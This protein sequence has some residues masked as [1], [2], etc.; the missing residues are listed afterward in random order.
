MKL[1][2]GQWSKLSRGVGEW[3]LQGNN[4]MK[5]FFFF[6]SAFLW[7]LIKLSKP[8]YTAEITF[9]LRYTNAPNNRVL[10]EPPPEEIKLLLQ[11]SGF[12]LSRY[13]WFSRKTLSVN[14]GDLRAAKEEGRYYWLPPRFSWGENDEINAELKLLAT[15]PDTLYFQYQDLERKKI[16]V[17]PQVELALDDPSL[18]LYGT[19]RLS[20]DSVWV[21]GPA[22]VLDSLHYV[23]TKPW[24]VREA[25]D[26]L[27]SEWRLEE[28]GDTASWRLE[29]KQVSAKISLSK[30]VEAEIEL[31]IRPVGLPDSLSVQLYPTKAKVT[32]RA[33]L[34][35]FP[36]L[37]PEELDLQVDF[38][39]LENY[40]ETRFVSIQWGDLPAKIKHLSVEPKR[41]EFILMNKL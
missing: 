4:R 8:D 9:P 2:K 39:I 18:R 12:A 15:R 17:R 36:Q 30:M 35:D 22:V 5:L 40:P 24:L 13:A 16:P 37:R 19:A 14:L 28:A 34:K 3:M 25:G 38:S 10:S 26:S 23:R 11:G 41:V 21:S 1:R 29:R 27:R 32:Y 31:P 20:P 6:F 33:F 7:L